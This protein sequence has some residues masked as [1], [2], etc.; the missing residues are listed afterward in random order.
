MSSEISSK[1]PTI[2]VKISVAQYMTKPQ[3][4]IT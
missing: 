1:V 3:I 4:F 2:V